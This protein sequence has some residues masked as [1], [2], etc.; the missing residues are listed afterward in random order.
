MVGTAELVL[1][2]IQAGVK[3]AKAGRTIY[4]EETIRGEVAF[5]LPLT[6]D[7]P[8]ALAKDRL[9]AL[10]RAPAGSR[11]REAFDEVYGPVIVAGDADRIVATYMDA[12]SRGLIEPLALPARERAGLAMLRQWEKGDDLPSPLQRVA[13]TLV[14]VAVDYFVHVPGA[15]SQDSATGRTLLSFLKGLDDVEFDEARWDS[16]L[17]ALFTAGLDAVKANPELFSDDDS[18]GADAG[19]NILRTAVSGVAADLA[20]R[21]KSLEGPGAFDA[22]DRLKRFGSLVLRSV[23][24]GAGRNLIDNPEVLGLRDA[25]RKALVT[26]VGTAFLDLLLDES[27]EGIELAEGLRRVASTDG[28]ASLVHAS[29]RVVAQHPDLVSTRRQP[30]DAWLANVVRGLFDLYPEPQNLFDPELLSNVAYLVLTHGVHDLEPLVL[31]NLARGKRALAV[32]LASG[33]L[34]ALV[35]PPA[36]GEPAVWSLEV[37]RDEL[38]DIVS[39]ALGAVSAHPQ[40]LFAKASHA[41]IAAAVLPLAVEAI[42]G[43]ASG[44]SL[45]ALVRSGR[46]EGVLA[47]V[48]S[49]GVI[50]PLRPDG[51]N[52]AAAGAIAGAVTKAISR[53]TEDGLAGAAGLLEYGALHDLLVAVRKAGVLDALLGADGARANAALDRI[54]ALA[55]S[56]RTAGPLTVPEMTARLKAA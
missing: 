12:T 14:G 7:S 33:V 32:E 25:S 16:I 47:A 3:L 36:D 48:L 4:V 20:E 53:I 44:G 26:G 37:S 40:W 30:V 15:I 31:K 52:P 17:I 38:S 6:L 22:E 49:S 54:V 39:G 34:G 28:L 43:A 42:A 21:L 35:T 5:P 23:V 24:E 51:P 8:V 11:A 1:F 56:L 2:A 41:K 46:L 19:A 13:G 9:K 55:G 50:E 29:M 18:T 10:S 27:D 45:K